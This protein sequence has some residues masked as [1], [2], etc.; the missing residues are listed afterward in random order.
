MTID[1]VAKKQ[2]ELHFHRAWCVTVLDYIMS[3]D[4]SADVYLSQF[5]EIVSYCFSK[6]DLRGLKTIK[7]DLN[8]LVL[9]LSASQRDELST[10]M[11]LELGHLP[12]SYEEEV[13]NILARGEVISNREYRLL[14]NYIDSL[15]SKNCMGEIERINEI[16]LNYIG[17]TN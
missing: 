8:E 5:K 15:L 2:A 9:E 10:L 7:S 14:N 11:S 16:L 6:N 1:K 13:A 4:R 12:M 3:T 17:R